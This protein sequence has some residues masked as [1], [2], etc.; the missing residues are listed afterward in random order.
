MIIYAAMCVKNE[1][2]IVRETI[3]HALRWVDA[4]FVIDN[5]SDDD[6]FKN[7]ERI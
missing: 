1:A 6:T 3:A 4:I 5:G 7:F 2:D